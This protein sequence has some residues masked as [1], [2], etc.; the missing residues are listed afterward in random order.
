MKKTAFAT[1]AVHSPD[2][3]DTVTGAVMP[4][5]VTSTTFAQSE[6][7]KP[8][9][10]F[11]YTRSQNPT[12]QALEKQ[13]AQLDCGQ[14]AYAFASGCAALSTLL[15]CL[16]QHAHV[17]LSDDVYGGTM[18][19]FEKVFADR[20]LSYSVVDFTDS[21][22]VKDAITHQTQLMWCETPSNPLLKVIDIQKIA[23]YKPVNCWLAVD[24]TFA[25]SYLQQPLNYGADLVC[26]STTKYIGGHSDVLGGALICNDA[27][28][29]EKIAYYQNAIGAVPSPWDCYLLLRSIK[30]LALRMRQHCHNAQLIAEYLEEHAKVEK[31]LYPGLSSHPQH[32]TA[33]MQMADFGGMITVVLQGGL[34]QAKQFMSSLSLFTLAESLGGVESL[35]EHPAMM[36]HAAIDKAHR[37]KIG[38]NDGLVR[39]SVGIEDPND[40]IEDIEQ[41]L[42]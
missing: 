27:T 31:V 15:H 12:R 39:M 26:Y 25:T 17:V 9:G 32:A 24:N 38:I 40:L 1:Q 28:L 36:T 6:P 7:A 13:L 21:N 20:Q 22:A 23:S 5:I 19:I 41:A 37:D 8:I 16:P 4:S 35:I 34:A 30:T 29:G 33:A 42:A 10:E 14:F 18:R 2:M 11:E 3:I